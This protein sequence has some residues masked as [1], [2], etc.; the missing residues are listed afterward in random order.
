MTCARARGL[1]RRRG[2]RLSPRRRAQ[3]RDATA[4]PGARAELA[5]ERRRQP[6]RPAQHVA[7][8]QRALAAPDEREEPDAAAGRELVELAGRAVRGAREDLLDGRRQGAEELPEGPVALEGEQRARTAAGDSP[9][10]LAAGGSAGTARWIF[11][12]AAA[13]ATRSRSES[14]SRSG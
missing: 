1:R 3:R 9:R 14:G 2:R 12:P 11:R 7:G 13:N 4:G 8:D 6:P 10:G 5:A